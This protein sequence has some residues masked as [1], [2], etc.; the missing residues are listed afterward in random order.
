V[1]ADTAIAMAQRVGDRAALASALQARG[2]VRGLQHDPDGA[3]ED[4]R[5]ALRLAELIGAHDL[6]LRNRNSLLW[7]PLRRGDI[8]SMEVE[9]TTYAQRAEE[10]R[11]PLYIWQAAAYKAMLALLRG[12][13]DECESLITKAHVLALHTGSEPAVRGSLWQLTALRREQGRLA[14]VEADVRDVAELPSVPTTWRDLLLLIECELGQIGE[15]SDRLDRHI[16][17]IVESG[18]FIDDAVL[19]AESCAKLGDRKYAD[20]LYERL[21]PFAGEVPLTTPPF[22]VCQG[23][24]ARYLGM[25]A[26][27]LRRWDAARDHFEQAITMH[28]RMGARPLLGH[29]YR[30][31][32]AMLLARCRRGD[33]H[34]AQTLLA[35]ALDIYTELGMTHYAAKVRA[36]AAD[37]SLAATRPMLAY[38]NGL[39]AR[40]IEVLRL[41]AAGRTNREIAAHLVISRN[42]VTRH[43]SH[44]FRKTNG[45]NRAEAATYA[46]R[47]GL[48]E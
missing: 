26:T 29:T 42:T 13:F 10:L 6:A 43:V 35:R 1:V 17:A 12:R 25:L 19:I 20:W 34:T 21:L 9:L 7:R 28:E 45:A 2:V 3:L 16:A 37:P 8:P 22:C 38:P 14:E 4:N 46:A 18:F 15:G 39:S 31:Y 11:Q 24:V 23:S 44:I 36:L 33:L 27:T 40:E 32:A 47:H 5:A 48:L 30:D 41:L